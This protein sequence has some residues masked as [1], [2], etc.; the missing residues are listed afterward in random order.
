MKVPHYLFDKRDVSTPQSAAE[1]PA[2]TGRDHDRCEQQ[3]QHA[4]T[5][6]RE[7]KAGCYRCSGADPGSHAACYQTGQKY[8]REQGY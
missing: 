6:A 1:Y 4:R 8:R 7:P 2:D 3:W 5:A